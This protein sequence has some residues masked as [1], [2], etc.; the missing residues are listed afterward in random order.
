[1]KTDLQYT[2]VITWSP[3]DQAFVVIL[4]EWEGYFAMPVAD[5]PTYEEAAARGHNALE[6]MIDFA[7]ETN[8]S[9]PKPDWH[10]VAS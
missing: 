5:G 10:A 1:M 8:H 2:M 7:R 6:N 4:R 9:L 3:Q